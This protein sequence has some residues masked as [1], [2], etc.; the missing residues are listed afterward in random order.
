MTEQQNRKT[1]MNE[2]RGASAFATAKPEEVFTNAHVILGDEV[3]DG[4]VVVRDGVIA[5]IQPGRTA[6]P[7]HDMEGDYLTPGLVELHTDHLETHYSPRPGVVW[8]L[9]ASVQAYD[10]QIATSGITTVFDCF[11]MGS[12]EDNGY[13]PGEMRV[14]FRSA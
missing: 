7:A 5:D 9:M 3:I 1:I 10:A 6:V 8:N 12:D 14:W 13:E 2:I 4:T 11:R